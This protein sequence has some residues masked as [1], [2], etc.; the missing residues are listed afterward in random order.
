MLD[1]CEMIVYLNND[2]E[3]EKTYPEKVT[4]IYKFYIDV[5]VIHLK[6]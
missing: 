3:N 4:I 6:R 2:I 5:C 1:Y